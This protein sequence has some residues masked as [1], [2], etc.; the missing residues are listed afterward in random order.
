LVALGFEL[1]Q[2]AKIAAADIIKAAATTFI[3]LFIRLP[4]TPLHPFDHAQSRFPVYLNPTIQ[5]GCRVGHDL[6]VET[7][8]CRWAKACDPPDQLAAH[9]KLVSAAHS[10]AVASCQTQ[11]DAPRAP[12]PRPAVMNSEISAALGEAVRPPTLAKLKA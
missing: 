4:P 10:C 7:I 11:K 6:A 1:E 3:D 5:A 12:A 8:L 2:A 9:R